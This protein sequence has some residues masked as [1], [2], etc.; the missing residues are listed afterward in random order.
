[1][2]L[3]TAKITH[4]TIVDIAD[5]GLLQCQKHRSIQLHHSPQPTSFINTSRTPHVP[6]SKTKIHQKQ[7]PPFEEHS[8]LVE[9]LS[10]NDFSHK[11]T[12]PFEFVGYKPLGIKGGIGTIGDYNSHVFL[13]FSER[14]V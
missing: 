4:Q 7:N 2:W 5:F 10:S 11:R 13:C 3:P 9:I 14:T 6:T 8:F 1:M 12:S